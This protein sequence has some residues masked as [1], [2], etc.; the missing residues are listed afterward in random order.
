MVYKT[1]VTI[2]SVIIAGLAV[3][4]AGSLVF[5]PDR[6]SARD[7]AYAWLEAKS[8]PYV[9]GIE[10]KSANGA[11]TLVQKNAAWFVS[12][13]GQDYPAKE[14]RVEDFLNLLSKKDSYP[15]RGAEAASHERL[16][17]LEDEAARIT[18]RGGVATLLD[19]LVGNTDA[20]G[21]EAYLRK[22]GKNEA[23]SGALSIL[24][25]VSDAKTAWYNLRLFPETGKLTVDGVQ[26][27]I[28]TLPPADNGEGGVS[29]E[30]ADASA[31]VSPAAETGSP[32]AP[33]TLTFVRANGGWT[34]N[35]QDADASKV[36]S[37]IRAILDAEGDD[38]A[39]GAF[40]GG[41]SA[42]FNEGRIVLELGDGTSRVISVGAKLDSNKR[43]ASISGSPYVYSLAGWVV[44]R[45]FRAESEFKK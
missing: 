12:V 7:A 35:G 23:R 36:E 24:N 14:R 3:V 2:L 18:A 16:G 1:K 44:E 25:Y 6:V 34:V 29:G 10:L 15:V 40:A 4:Y 45:L 43:N 21:N 19:L 17:L 8:V 41:G 42:S 28:V 38:F 22:A 11:V 31:D 13:D 27:V 30:P 5:D 9:D 37:Y 33:V 32:A 26:R 39:A 20:S